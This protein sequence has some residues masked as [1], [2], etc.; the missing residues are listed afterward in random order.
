MTDRWTDNRPMDRWMHGKIMLFSHTLTMRVSDVAS[1]VEFL[2]M[3][4][5]DKWTD[6]GCMNRR[7]QR[8]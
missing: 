7:T 4:V 8:K 3:V 1:L 2:P 5:T 6:N